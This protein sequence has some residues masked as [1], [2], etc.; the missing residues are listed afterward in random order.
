MVFSMAG[1]II[2][3]SRGIILG[4]SI[5]SWGNTYPLASVILGAWRTAGTPLSFRVE[6]KQPSKKIAN[7]A[8]LH[9]FTGANVFFVEKEAIDSYLLAGIQ[10]NSYQLIGL[11]LNVLKFNRLTSETG[12]EPGQG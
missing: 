3:A 8:Y 5:L 2:G 9:F 4:G 7:M 12:R 1:T 6:G 10:G 11:L